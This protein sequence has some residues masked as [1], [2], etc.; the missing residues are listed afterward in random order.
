MRRIPLALVCVVA[1]ALA[2]PVETARA[3]GPLAES[4]AD[5]AVAF[6]DSQQ[7]PDGG[8][9]TAGFPG[10][11]TPDAVLA[12]AEGAQANDSWNSGAALSA[13]QSRHYHGTGPTPLDYLDDF[14][15]GAYGPLTAGQAAK[16]IVLVTGPLGIDPATFNPQG[17]MTATNLPK[18]MD[19][20]R[21]SDGSYGAFSATL[22]AVLAHVVLGRAVP[23]D[24]AQLVVNAQ[25]ANGGWNFAGD[26]S[27]TDQDVDTTGLAVQ[28]LIAAGRAPGTAS[29][30]KA[31][32]FLASIQQTSGGW[33]AFGSLDPNSTAVAMTGLAA[34]GLDVSQPCWRDI[35]NPEESDDALPV[36]ELTLR[37]LQAED[38]HVASPNDS[39]GVSTFATSQS[40]HALRRGWLPVRR[41]AGR[42]CPPRS[43][44]FA[45]GTTRDGFNEQLVLFNTNPT[46]RLQVSVVYQFSQDTPN[47]PVQRF[48]AVEP[49]SIRVISVEQEIGTSFDVSLDVEEASPPCPPEASPCSTTGA[50]VAARL[51]RFDHAL[52]PG[53]P[54]WVGEDTQVGTRSPARSW[55]FGEGT[56]LP[57]FTEFLTLQN[58]DPQSAST[59]SLSYQT[60]HCDRA[61][62]GPRSITLP[63]S[64]RTTIRVSDATDPNGL[65]GATCT[66]VG[67]TVEVTSG[68][69]IVAERP[70]YFV[71]DFGSGMV[72]DGHDAF[73][74]TAPATDLLFAEGTSLPGF[75]EFL[76]LANPGTKNA[77][78]GIDYQTGS[79]TEIH[80][81]LTVTAA[82]RTTIQ[83]YN[84]NDP[85]GLGP[86]ETGISARVRS[87][88]PIS[89][90]RPMYMVHDFGGGLVTGGHVARG[91]TTPGD[92]FTAITRGGAPD[93]QPYLTIENTDTL[94]AVD[95]NVAVFGTSGRLATVGKSVPAHTR[96]TFDLNAPEF[97]V[98]GAQSIGVVVTTDLGVAVEVPSYSSGPL[99]GASD[100]VGYRR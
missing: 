94:R 88:V 50:L 56:T 53:A 59:V 12:V 73:G 76:T 54:R 46:T 4:A 60:E 6:I 90:E 57:D 7:Q 15:D 11:E 32:A 14:A 48:Y 84:P 24:T 62:P 35:V 41:V 28:A 85:G 68:P 3:A 38:G 92:R 2:A 81:D 27:G 100:V 5:K 30:D 58:P 97:G 47:A 26:S 98:S 43:F 51:L 39:F 55:T 16:L 93:A 23:A 66:G 80:R 13:V 34:A 36:P 70:L 78:V 17:D 49:S 65:L 95:A 52:A 21:Q 69:S 86:N 1:A 79:G 22:Y 99:D 45:E 91:A 77:G 8:Y 20:G 31:V 19:N 37:T 29:V 72:S 89:A 18:V 87:T 61:I 74:F 75:H 40:V 82:T 33:Q 10:F 71:H 63:G 96:A 9:E 42:S 83:V 64:S 67:A 44:L 25:Q